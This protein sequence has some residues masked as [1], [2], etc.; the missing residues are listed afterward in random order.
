MIHCISTDCMRDGQ[1]MPPDCEK[2]ETVRTRGKM[3]RH[4]RQEVLLLRIIEIT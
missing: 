2:E 1:I 4:Q 3:E